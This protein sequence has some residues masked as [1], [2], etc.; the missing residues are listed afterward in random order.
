M[1]I[2]AVVEE[3][4]N[5]FHRWDVAAKQ[6]PEYPPSETIV[7]W[8][9]GDAVVYKKPEWKVLG[10][11]GEIPDTDDEEQARDWWPALDWIEYD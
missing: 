6:R 11:I 5:Y 7:V 3:G 8:V 4:E 2:W 9:Y 1:K 10:C